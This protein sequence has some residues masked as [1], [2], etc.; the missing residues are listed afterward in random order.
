MGQ[1]ISCFCWRTHDDFTENQQHSDPSQLPIAPTEP[2]SFSLRISAL[3]EF[4]I[5]DSSSYLC[6][7]EKFTNM[8]Q[9]DETS[10]AKNIWSYFRQQW[11]KRANTDTI[12]VFGSHQI[13]VHKDI[14]SCRCQYFRSM[15]NSGM[16]ESEQSIIEMEKET[17]TSMLGVLEYLYCDNIANFDRFNMLDL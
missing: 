1:H 6:D 4:P 13:N 11:I 15:F 10:S 9:Q 3:K 2:H 7:I 17:Y 12:L 16:M 5:S 8:S 14:L